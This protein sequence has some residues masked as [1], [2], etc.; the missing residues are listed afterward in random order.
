MT[1]PVYT[2][3]LDTMARTIWGEARGEA[4][5]GKIAVAHVILNRV[6]A[7]TWWGSDIEGVCKKAWQFSAW[8]EDDPNRPQ[9]QNLEL[10]KNQA[11][12]ECLAAAAAAIWGLERDP[13]AVAT[14][15]MTKTRREAGWPT[16]W[17][18]AKEPH[19]EIGVHLFYKGIA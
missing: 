6:K 8:N 17:G 15:Y 10:S 13:T 3:A 1:Q 7:D 5:I 19:R 12:R 9:M 14:H 16:S 2:D 4:W 11:F 18:E